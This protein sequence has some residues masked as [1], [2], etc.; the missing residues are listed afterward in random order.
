MEET[1]VETVETEVVVQKDTY[2][3]QDGNNITNNVD[4]SNEP[5]VQ[6]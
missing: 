5:G 1:P 6:Q 2:I 4:P 3:D